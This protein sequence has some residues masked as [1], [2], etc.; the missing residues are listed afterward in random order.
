VNKRIRRLCGAA[1]ALVL[2]AG[3]PGVQAQ[4][5]APVLP[6]AVAPRV[7]VGVMVIQASATPGPI[8]SRLTPL[9]PTL[10]TLPF[11]AFTLLD[12][13]DVRLIDGATEAVSLAGDRRL[14]VQLLSHDAKEARVRIELMAGEVQLVDTTISIHRNRSFYVAVRGGQGTTLILP[15]SV[16]Y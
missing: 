1:V 10:R 2:L 14:R 5:P 9:L 11:Q 12:E 6:T 13:H 4:T 8:D 16:R 3:A 15:V 7:D